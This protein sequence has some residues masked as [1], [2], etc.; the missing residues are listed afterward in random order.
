MGSVESSPLT[1]L[2]TTT[3]AAARAR[4]ENFPVASRLVPA[5]WRRHLLAVY[6]FARLTDDIGDESDG[7]RLRELDWLEAEL[8][9]AAAGEAKHPAMR[10]LQETIFEC[11]LDVGECR[12]LIEANRQDQ[13]VKRYETFDDLLAYCRLSA[14]PVGRLVLSIIGADDSSLHVLSDD[15][16]AG[17][18]VV[19]HLQDV[20]E[21][22]RAGRIYLPAVDMRA[23]GCSESDLLAD[24]ASPALRRVI[25]AEAA[26]A[27]LLLN[28]GQPLA[29]RLNG[30][31]RMAISG[32]AA[33]GMAA[34]DS[35]AKAD[36][37][38]LAVSCKPRP[39]SFARHFLGVLAAAGLDR[40]RLR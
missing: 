14:M 10:R 26:R 1:N 3:Q 22:A 21:D 20:G 4:R 35:I 32:F 13:L 29:A 36:N 2:V 15:V 5:R 24:H 27:A 25:S 30:R 19:E 31:G 16:C 39:G 8:D 38:V 34:L 7:D 37:D 23:A 11:G 18:Q 40:R 28:S 33:G 17:L 6:G 9:A 12:R